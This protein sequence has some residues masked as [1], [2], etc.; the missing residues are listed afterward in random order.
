MSRWVAG[1]PQSSFAAYSLPAG[2]H[3][4]PP[5]L[6]AEN[7]R[8]RLLGAA[9]EALAE[10]GYAK[11]TT[12]EIATRAGVSSATFYKY[13]DGLS[14]CLLAAYEMA[15]ECISQLASDACRG[16]GEGPTRIRAALDAVLDFL[17]AEPALAH[18]LGADGPAG[19]PA[20]A[21]VRDRLLD[22]L[23]DLLCA[24]RAPLGGTRG[25]LSPGAERYLIGGAF[26]LLADLIAA[27]EAQR[28][29][30]LAAELAELLLAG[31]QGP[32][33]PQH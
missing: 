20:I 19:V 26:S 7:Q 28:L 23:A 29:P 13:F 30:Q 10:R 3:G 12:L 11:T 33:Q 14:A 18:L 25:A 24:A 2:R 1:T 9:A 31:Q 32:H 15:A 5:D 21:A 8:W 17:T 4:L 22:R 16:G 27:G 6:V